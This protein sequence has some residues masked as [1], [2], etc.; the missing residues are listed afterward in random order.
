MF[1]N[2]A[3][4][5]EHILDKNNRRIQVKLVAGKLCKKQALAPTPDSFAAM[6]ENHVQIWRIS[7]EAN[8]SWTLPA[9]LQNT[10]KILFFYDGEQIET[11]GFTIEVG[12]SL[13]LNPKESVLI[14]NGNKAAEFLLLEGMPINEPVV[15][16]GPFVANSRSEMTA[17]INNY[18]QTQYGG[19]PHDV[20]EKV[21]P[22]EAGRFAEHA[23]GRVEHPPTE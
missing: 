13:T 17:I 3:I 12:H 22:K 5:V 21:H 9:S 2:E 14:N 15:Q 19:W 1:W 20:Y 6:A 23:D 16:Q 7:M 11:D 4:P 8:A 10:N 18:Q